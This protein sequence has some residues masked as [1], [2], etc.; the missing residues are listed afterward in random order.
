M[1][2]VLLEGG[3]L[4]IRGALDIDR[5]AT[6]ISLRRLPA[7]TR[8]Q[9]SDAFMEA[10]VTMAAGMRVRFRTNSA[11]IEIDLATTQ[12]TFEGKDHVDAQLARIIDTIKA[13]GEWENTVVIVTSDHGEQLGDQGLIQKAGF[14]ESSYHIAAIVRDP[15]Y[16]K[17]AGTTVQQFTEA[18]DI[19]PT[20]CEAIGA[21][22]PAQC[23]G[24]PLTPFLR[25]DDPAWWRTSAHY[26][27]D[28]RDILIPATTDTWPWDRRLERSHL[29][30]QRSETRAYVHFGDGTWKCFDLEAD[31]TW[32]TEITDPAIVVEEVQAMLSWQTEHLDRNMTGMLLRNGGMGRWPAPHP[33][34]IPFI[35]TTT[36]T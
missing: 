4:E 35:N 18:V 30:V 8:A 19:M 29:T 22:I 32:R 34:A 17:A 7:W 16:P 36:G 26:E 1:Q 6:G 28:W 23:D 15:R 12:I 5:T 10:M 3:A 9:L 27:W 31:P 24:L 2:E 13:R 25:G 11:R 14:F 20:V 21:E 33:D